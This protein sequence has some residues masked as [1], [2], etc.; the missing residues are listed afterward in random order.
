MRKSHI[1]YACSTT[2]T[3][4]CHMCTAKSCLDHLAVRSTPYS[5]QLVCKSCEDAYKVSDEKAGRRV[6]IAGMLF[7]GSIA[8][9]LF[10]VWANSG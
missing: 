1:C 2:A 8:A 5:S 3:I 7:G 6:S 9:V 10:L 4:L